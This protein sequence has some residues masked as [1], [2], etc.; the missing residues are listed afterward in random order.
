MSAR[1]GNRAA[2]FSIKYVM[3][4]LPVISVHKAFRV[5]RNRYVCSDVACLENEHSKERI[6][7]KRYAF[8]GKHFSLENGLWPRP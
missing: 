2:T 8:R 7:R 4:A 3:R 5:P 1:K 6:T